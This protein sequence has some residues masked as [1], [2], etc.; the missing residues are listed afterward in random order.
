MAGDYK[1]LAEVV[2]HNNIK[3]NIFAIN[4]SMQ[5]EKTEQMHLEDGFPSIRLYRGNNHYTEFGKEEYSSFK[6]YN[7]PDLLQYL[8][9]NKVDIKNAK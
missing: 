6:T 3:V 8:K 2:K 5:P 1:Q 7:K 9:Q 4:V